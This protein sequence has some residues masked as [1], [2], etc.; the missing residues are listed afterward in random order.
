MFS[1][2][3]KIYE[4]SCFDIQAD[5]YTGLWICD[6]GR[7][8]FVNITKK[9]SCREHD[10]GFFYKKD[11]I[12]L[13]ELFNNVDDSIYIYCKYHTTIYPIL[14]FDLLTEQDKIQMKKILKKL[15]EI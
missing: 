12:I 9:L 8:E 5:K 14:T 11:F 13:K 15:K 10:D 2:K 1:K 7:F 6:Y 4:F 3:N